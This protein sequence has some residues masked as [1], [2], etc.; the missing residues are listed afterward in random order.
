M[1]CQRTNG[2]A[3]V[4]RI[5]LQ[6]NWQLTQQNGEISCPA[7]VP[8]DNVSALLAAGIIED[9]YFG[10]NELDVQWICEETWVWEREFVVGEELLTHE[11]VYLKAAEVDTCAVIRINGK[12]VGQTVSQFIG[13]RFEVKQ[14]L[15]PGLNR[16]SIAV[17]PFMKEAKKRMALSPLPVP[18][19]GNCTI[20]GLNFVRKTHCH[21]GWDWGISLVV[22]GVYGDLSLVGYNAARIE[23]VYTRQRHSKGRCRVEVTAELVA[24]TAGETEL[25]VEFDGTC[26]TI[27]VALVAG[28]T[29]ARAVFTVEKPRLW[30]PAGYG[31][32]PL[33]ALTVRTPDESRKKWLGLRELVVRSEPDDTGIPLVV[34]V[35][36]LPI[37]CKG[38]NWIPLDALP[39]R[40]SRA[41]YKRLLGDA[42][43]ANMNMVRVWGGGHYE[44]DEFYEVCDQLG[45]LI[46]HDFMFACSLYPAYPAFREEV[47]REVEYQ[48]KRLR[49]HAS[50]ALWCGDNEVVGALGWYQEAKDNRDAYVAGFERL[51]AAKEEGLALAGDDRTFWPS[52]PCSGSNPFIGDAWHD[53]ENGDMHFW[54]VWHSG[55]D[56]EAYYD[57]APRFCSEFGF[58]SFSSLETVKTFAEAKDFNA[59]SPVME[60]HQKNRAGNQK[61]LEMF[62]RYFRMPNGF[63]NFL[64]LSQVQQALAI[65]TGVEF[66]RHLQPVCMGTLYWQLNDNWPVASWSSLEY[67][68]A[69]K[70]LH[71]HARRF[72][73][74]VLGC[75]FQS[76][77]GELALWAVSELAG[78]AQ[79]EMVATVYDFAGN[80]LRRKTYTGRVKTRGTKK[81]A[82]LR[83]G[84][85]V[86]EP[87][88][89]FMQLT[90]CLTD[91]TGQKHLHENT[92]FFTRFKACELAAA[93]VGTKVARTKD[94]AFVVDLT[95]DQPAFFVMAE[96]AGISG[97]F[98]DNSITLLPGKAGRRLLFTPRQEGVRIADIRAGLAVKHLQ[99]T[100][101]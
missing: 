23:H 17:A 45:L 91:E 34:E 32:Q 20:A 96:V 95:T 81:L 62:T 89:C 73:Q 64:Y 12:K 26:Q 98:D 48:V 94:G 31:K 33:Y 30:W 66:W 55:K 69:W 19:S 6:G 78:R 83:V 24:A 16:I 37:F 51:L 87:S 93:R 40:Y 11:Q 74:P 70:Q 82:E 54:E 25:T 22:S 99:Q 47:T 71:Y 49:D 21:G 58:Q 84:S 42:K 28:T 4:N 68:G 57:V 41:R 72:Y 90:L 76:A 18:G 77:A 59:T 15:Q 97:I 43:L 88:A 2:K 46:W 36:G 29:E 86:E 44:R 9:P 35:N 60:H 38:A 92:H 75:A 56:I 101:G 50:I 3:L 27:P 67:N 39:Q 14:A 10:R 7:E 63:E 80:K 52:S 100:Y 1:G 8:G 65:K 61:I 5:D 53:A 79:A 13:H 85:F